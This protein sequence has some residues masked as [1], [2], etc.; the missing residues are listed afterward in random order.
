MAAVGQFHLDEVG[1][2]G[3]GLEIGGHVVMENAHA[4]AGFDLPARRELR[5][6]F[7][8]VQ[9]LLRGQALPFAGIGLAAQLLEVA[10]SR[11]R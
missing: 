10:L 2:L 1:R 3:A 7:A 5:G 11:L 4:T 6:Q 8:W 9:R